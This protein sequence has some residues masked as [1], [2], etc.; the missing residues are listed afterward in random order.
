MRK[1]VASFGAIFSNIFVVKRS[2]TKQE[3]ERIKVPLAYG[4]AERYLVR[5]YEDPEL[6]RNYAIKLP[7]MSFEIKTLE[8]DS[9]RKLN[10]IKKNIAAVDGTPGT[11]ARQY[12]GVPYKITIELSIISKFID[13]A[14]QIVEQI[15]PWFTP[16]F[17]ITINSI[18]E[19]NYKDDIAITLT[20]INVQDSYEDDWKARRDIIWTLSFDIKA[21]FYGPIIDKEL[22]TS[23][24]TDIYATAISNIQNQ[25]ALQTVARAGRATVAVDPNNA[26]Y[27][28]EF[29]YTETYESFADSKS[30]DSVTGEDVIVYNK[31]ST[32]SIID[33]KEKVEEPKLS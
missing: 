18:P 20:G 23:A 11:V 13:D 17:T 19:M 3:I 27:K 14:N 22:I 5:T 4:P 25:N 2:E 32:T 12:Q 24:I 10:T 15:L 7:R 6:N 31:I 1:I 29:G 33:S 26:T 9:N 30:R 28:D 21:T 16:A 8:Y